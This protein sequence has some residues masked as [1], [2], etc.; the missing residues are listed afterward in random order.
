ME[1]TISRLNKCSKTEQQAYKEFTRTI[2]ARIDEEAQWY[3]VKHPLKLAWWF[4]SLSNIAWVITAGLMIAILVYLLYNIR[5]LDNMG[6]HLNTLLSLMEQAD[7]IDNEQERADFIKEHHVKETKETIVQAAHEQ[8]MLI[9]HTEHEARCAVIAAFVC[10]M[11][12]VITGY[13]SLSMRRVRWQ[14]CRENT[15][16]CV[17]LLRQSN[18]FCRQLFRLF[19]EQPCVSISPI[20]VIKGSSRYQLLDILRATKFLTCQCK[21]I[22]GKFCCMYKA[23][24]IGVLLT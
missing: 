14:W 15:S 9:Y 7:Q 8:Q 6:Q 12:N 19:N 3:G 16:E 13:L 18:Q 22:R 21:F 23:D 5:A 17:S 4:Q 20:E 1:Q 2:D 24:N 11:I 10:K